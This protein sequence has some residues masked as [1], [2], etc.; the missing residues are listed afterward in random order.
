MRF[1]FLHIIILLWLGLSFSQ[2][3]NLAKTF[4]DDGDYE[5]ALIEY[6]KLIKKQPYRSDYILNA[7]KCHQEL[8]Q[9]D[10]AEQLLLSSLKP[11]TRNPHFIVEL[12]YNLD[13][14]KDSIGAKSHYQKAIKQISS[15]PN[16]ANVIGRAF[17]KY[18]L[19]NY[20]EQTYLLGIE[21][22]PKSN[23]DFQLARVYGQRNK[24]EKMFDSYLSTLEKN[25]TLESTIQR[26]ISQFINSDPTS[27]NNKLL[28]I[29]LLKKLQ[30]NPLTLWNEQLSWLYVQQ[31]EYDKAFRQEKAVFKRSEEPNLNRIFDLALT[32]IN[33]G[34]TEEAKEVFLFIA[35]QPLES[36]TALKVKEYLLEIAV[37]EA[38]NYE[39]VA[40]QYKQVFSE[41]GINAH[42]IELQ[43]DYCS[44]L[45]FKMNQA[46]AAIEFL[47]NN[48]EQRLG[49][50]NK[51]RYNMLLADILVVD[52]KFN[53]ALIYYSKIQRSLKNNVISQEARFKVAKTSYFKGD[54]DWA[55]QQVKVLKE[56]T[57]QLIANDA[58]DLHL[59]ISDH[60]QGTDDLPLAL[61]KYAAA[62]L[63]AFQGKNNE[64]I[65]KLNLLI[66]H[67][68][69]QPI[70]D[71]AYYLQAQLFEKEKIIEKAVTNY[72]F[73]INNLKESIFI[74]NAL[75]KLGKLHLDELN[76]PEKAKEYFELLLFN[77]ADSIHFVEAQKLYRKLRGDDI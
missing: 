61:E 52:N 3:A 59:L 9:F 40:N 77:H 14:Q 2:N 74:D 22:N 8:E 36:S 30:A 43:L 46:Q 53:Q 17:E 64:A 33:N 6:Q 75:F 57:S 63:L 27:E 48:K 44:L 49:R 62:D 38:T 70:E 35:E 42:T 25:K 69:G 32:A 23:L 20:A 50:F 34:K 45:A 15:K 18:N 10:N 54:F 12:G 51:A 72:E 11:T 19:L 26:Y 39:P 28:R 31:Q 65:E 66:T 13:L 5:K 76:K 60:K 55:L 47:K 68:K 7:V 73:I 1:S 71:D 4:F 67:Y 24:I 41:Q 56:S 58:L 21:L 16:Y 29:A 37:L